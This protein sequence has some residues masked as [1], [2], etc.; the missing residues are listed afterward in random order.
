MHFKLARQ[1]HFDFVLLYIIKLILYNVPLFILFTFLRSN[2]NIQQWVSTSFPVYHLSK[3]IML[4]AEIM[5]SIAGY[6]TLLVFSHGI[7]HYDV[8]SLQI[9][10]GSSVFLGFS[11]LGLTI[12][13]FFSTII[14]ASRG[15][16]I[17]KILYILSGFFLI[18]ILN[19]LRMS[20]L[21]WL[22]R[23]GTKSSFSEI[24]LLD[25]ITFDHHDIFNFF[26]YL[27]VFL[28]IILWFESKKIRNHKN[29]SPLLTSNQQQATLS[30]RVK[31]R[32]NSNKY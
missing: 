4:G 20:Y 30:L 3:V 28:L 19:V 22:L 6:Q 2:P 12:I 7:Y 24:T 8:F 14:I 17:I 31:R 27:I 10:G 9:I 11:C 15:K 16:S 26:I 23:D 18:Q 21:T 29:A 25:S 1:N 32:S 5:L 13:W